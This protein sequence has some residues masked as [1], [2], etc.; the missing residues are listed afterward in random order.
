MHRTLLF[1]MAAVLM[2]AQVTAQTNGRVLE[3]AVRAADDVQISSGVGG[4]E[5]TILGAASIA[6]ASGIIRH[7]WRQLQCDVKDGPDY[8]WLEEGVELKVILTSRE[9]APYPVPDP[10]SIRT[11]PLFGVEYHQ[12]GSRL[13]TWESQN[14]ACPSKVGLSIGLAWMAA[15]VAILPIWGGH[16][17]RNSRGP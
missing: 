3:S 15:G 4:W 14:S 11:R 5:R 8:S 6:A 9:E 10:R 13:L 2:A 7:S 16:G 1:V 12:F 17:K